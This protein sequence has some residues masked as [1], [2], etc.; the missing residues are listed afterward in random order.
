M[1]GTIQGD[2]PAPYMTRP[3]GG[4][5]GHAALMYLLQHW[6]HK[7]VAR[8]IKNISDIHGSP[9]FAWTKGLEWPS[10]W[11]S[12]PQQVLIGLFRSV[13]RVFP[14]DRIQWPFPCHALMSRAHLSRKPR[15]SHTSHGPASRRAFAK[16]R[17]RSACATRDVEL[18]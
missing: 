15:A 6:F 12:L 17:R 5:P 13:L 8:T 18:W 10:I 1:K 16:S 4:K 11:A 2:S 9:Y 7:K 3:V 14:E